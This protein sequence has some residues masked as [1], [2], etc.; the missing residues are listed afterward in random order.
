M[1]GGYWERLNLT[2]CLLTGGREAYYGLTLNIL[3]VYM[4][5]VEVLL[6][7]ANDNSD[8]GGGR[9]KPQ[10]QHVKQHKKLSIKPS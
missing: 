4:V 5:I 7:T 2:G 3:H 10:V 6:C 8:G 9:S 1:T